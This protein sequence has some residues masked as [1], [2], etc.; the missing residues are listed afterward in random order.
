MFSLLA[1]LVDKDNDK[2]LCIFK[3]LQH[4]TFRCLDYWRCWLIKTKTRFC[5]YLNFTTLNFQMS[6]LL[7]LYVDK[8]K[9][10]PKNLCIFKT[11]QTIQMSRLLVLLALLVVFLPNAHSASLPIRWILR[12]LSDRLEII[13]PR[14]TWFIHNVYSQN[15]CPSV[16]SWLR[17]GFLN[18]RSTWQGSSNLQKCQTLKICKF[19]LF[20]VAQNI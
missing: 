17:M 18:W 8:D 1:L 20:K 15:K 11:L 12:L 7:A 2:I 6:G 14:T 10:K 19:R 16:Q 9:D 4:L 3:T 13:D 5:A